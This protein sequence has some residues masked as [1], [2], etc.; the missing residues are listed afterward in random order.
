MP[1]L[2]AKQAPSFSLPSISGT[3]NLQKLQ[4]QVVYV[5]F[6][7]SWCSPCRKSFPWMNNIANKYKDMGLTVIAI[8]LDK[9]RE[10]AMEFLNDI[11]HGFTIAFDP[12]GEI[13]SQ[14]KVN[15]MPSS[16]LID[17][18]GHIQY[19]HFGFRDDKKSEIET[20]IKSLLKQ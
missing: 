13:A 6:W 19:T 20:N 9:E 15:A 18:N 17:R 1:A 2:A 3:V 7:A 8:N 10:L 4:G 12:E 14:Y 16:Y 5:D 11:P